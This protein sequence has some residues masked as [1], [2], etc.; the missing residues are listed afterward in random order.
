M[1]N[2]MVK[3]PVW[4]LRTPVPGTFMPSY[5]GSFYK[6]REQIALIHVNS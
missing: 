4:W 1:M 3:T 2:N 5:Y 6:D